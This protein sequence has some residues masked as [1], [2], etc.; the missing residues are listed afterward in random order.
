MGSLKGLTQ[1]NP[2]TLKE[3]KTSLPNGVV[4]LTLVK[5]PALLMEVPL[6]L[7]CVTS[8]RVPSSRRSTT[9]LKIPKRVP[10]SEVHHFL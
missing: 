10:R 2:V 7:R 5:G 3:V 1:L 4:T 8:F 9:S 6:G